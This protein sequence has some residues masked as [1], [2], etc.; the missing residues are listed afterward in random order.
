M[1]SKAKTVKQ[2]FAELPPDR[3]KAMSALRA[4]INKNLPKGFKEGM[5]WGMPAWYVPLSAY[6]DGYHCQPDEPLPFAAI[7]SQKQ[8]M[9]FYGIGLYM[10]PE[11]AAWFVKAW[12]A[13]GKKLNMGKSCVRFKK[14]ED[15]ALEVV[16]EAVRRISMKDYIAGYEA[17]L[18]QNKS[19]KKVGA[20]RS[21]ARKKVAAKKKAVK[22]TAAK[23]K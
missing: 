13:T 12:E 22:K 14:I 11:Q 19:G 18:A 21:A 20:K 17:S 4:V 23:K 5:Q 16:G 10:D 9:A 8:H 1:Q 15:V 7:A 6:P 3:R 2:Y